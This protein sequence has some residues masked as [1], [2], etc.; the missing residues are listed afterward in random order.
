[1]RLSYFETGGYNS[2]LYAYESDVL[3]YFSIPVLY[4]KGYRY[5][6]NINYDFSRKLSVWAKWAQTIYKDKTVI[7][8]GLDE[9]TGNRKSEARIELLY[10]F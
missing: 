4:D 2:R 7:G 6:F 9:I 1:M 10:K 5:Y 8:S 3:Y